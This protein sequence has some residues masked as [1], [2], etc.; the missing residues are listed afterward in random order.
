MRADAVVVNALPLITLFRSSQADLLPRLF[1]RIV[2]PDAVWNEVV[3]QESDDD[4]GH[5]RQQAA[6]ARKS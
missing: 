1:N 5:H 6:R 2:V 4:S 3:V